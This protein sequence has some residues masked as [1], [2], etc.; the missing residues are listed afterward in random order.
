MEAVN[1]TL[2]KLESEGKSQQIYNQWFGPGT[3]AEQ[4][5]GEFKFAPL[6]DQPK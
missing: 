2:L 3:K 6:A 1:K 5:R 4:P